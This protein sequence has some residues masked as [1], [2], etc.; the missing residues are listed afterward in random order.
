MIKPSTLFIKILKNNKQ[1]VA[2]IFKNNFNFKLQAQIGLFS[3]KKLL[4]MF[5]FFNKNEKLF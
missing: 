1:P 5:F 2:L 3:K 4:I